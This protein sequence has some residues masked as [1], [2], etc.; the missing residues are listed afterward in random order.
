MSLLAWYKLENLVATIGGNATG[1]GTPVWSTGKFNNGNYNGDVTNY[2][3]VPRPFP[4]TGTTGQF[5]YYFKSNYDVVDGVPSDYGDGY[6]SIFDTYVASGTGVVIYFNPAG[7]GVSSFANGGVAEH[8]FATTGV[9]WSAGDNVYIKFIWDKDAGFDGAKTFALYLNGVEILSST[10]TI[11]TGYN[12]PANFVVGAATGWTAVEAAFGVIDN[13]M[14]RDN[15]IAADLTDTRMYWEDEEGIP[16]NIVATDGTYTNKVN[17]SWNTV[18]G[19]TVKYVV[20]R[21]PI[22]GGV[23]VDISG[24]IIAINY[25]DITVVPGIT[26]WYKVKSKTT[27]AI[28][29][30]S[31]EDSG[32]AQ[33]TAKRNIVNK[34]NR[35]ETNAKFNYGM[36][37]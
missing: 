19:D 15:V 2:V 18:V 21:A 26:Y 25:D 12:F 35:I 22:S 24:D 10:N 33:A 31:V 17:I 34:F 27:L 28:S 8:I 32:Y 16:I 9:N 1:H 3:T 23:F 14:I 7:F 29:D 20:Y 30:Y 11:N 5:T 37:S 4:S 6:K 13:L 36:T